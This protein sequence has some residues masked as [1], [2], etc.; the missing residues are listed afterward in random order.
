MRND[1]FI[2]H[3]IFEALPEV[4]PE[5]EPL[6][7]QVAGTGIPYYGNEFSVT[8]KRKRQLERAYF[9]FVY[10]PLRGENRKVSGIMVVAAEVTETVEAKQLLQ[11]SEKHF[12]NMVM[13]SPIP[14]TIL[15]GENYIIESANKV[16][17]HDVWR[18]KEDEVI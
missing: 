4:K 1:E 9:N 2:G 16:M 10:H 18:K 6:F 7:E 17:F 15:K 14:M 11:E 3:P 8:L 12:R 5:V 13:Q